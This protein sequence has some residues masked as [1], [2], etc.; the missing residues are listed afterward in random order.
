MLYQECEKKGANKGKRMADSKDWN[1]KEELKQ[2]LYYV[3]KQ[4]MVQ[5]CVINI[6]VKNQQYRNVSLFFKC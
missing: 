3:Y 4:Q 1:S 5:I 6:S 2:W